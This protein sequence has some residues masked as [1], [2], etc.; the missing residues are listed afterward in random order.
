MR[1][2]YIERFMR[3][4]G[5]GAVVALVVALL[6][7]CGGSASQSGAPTSAHPLYSS[8]TI[9]GFGSVHLNGKKFDTSNAKIMVN[10]KSATQADLHAGDVVE[11][12]A[13]H[14]ANSG[15]DVADEVDFRANVRG[16]L[17]S[18]DATP[19]TDPSTHMLVVLG[20]TVVVSSD[21][22]YGEGISPASVA[23][24]KIGDILEV[25]GYPQANGD[26]LATRVDRKP[27]GTSFEVLGSM[28]KTD[29][30]AKTFQINALVIDYSTASLQNFPSSGPA[31]GI[32]VEAT[33]ATLGTQ[34]ALL[35]TEVEA[36]GNQEMHADVNADAE[37]EGPVTRYVSATDFDVA[38]HKVTTSDSTVYDNGAAA[39]LATPHVRVEVEGLVDSA[40]TLVASKIKFEHGAAVRLRA[41]VDA[42]DTTSSPNTVTVLGVKIAVNDLTRYEDHSAEH[43]V[44]F[45]LSNLQMGAWVEVRGTESP[46][47]SNQLTA[48]RVERLET[49]SD[50]ELAGPVKAA[51]QPQFTILAVPVTTTGTTVFSDATGTSTTADAFYTGLVDKYADAH[52]SWDGTTLTAVSAT[53]ANQED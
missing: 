2:N 41:Q 48:N 22:S 20:Q 32:V 49:Q 25:S 9:T 37:Y 8:G 34:G 12:K 24:L 5:R 28:S 7:S 38:G 14:D 53:L 50:V 18:I 23:G 17:A 31:D 45:N 13:H 52:G 35:A 11:V 36:P 51:T 30:I 33:G 29:S 39:D 43:L 46:A 4:T 16:P 6:A 21:T 47:G 15:A 40:G 44:T 26:V 19:P 10:G 1:H 42:F 3:N 27:A